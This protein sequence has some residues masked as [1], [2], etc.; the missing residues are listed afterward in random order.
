MSAA[1]TRRLGRIDGTRVCATERVG[2]RMRRCCAN[3]Q[4]KVPEPA[5]HVVAR[6]WP[7]KGGGLM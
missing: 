2:T 7:T 1:S 4:S 5:Q 3:H 6:H